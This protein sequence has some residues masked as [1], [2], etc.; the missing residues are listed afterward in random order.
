[1]ESDDGI[2]SSTEVLNRIDGIEGLTKRLSKREADEIIKKFVLEKWLC[3]VCY[4]L[5]L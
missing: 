4:G 5:L 3:Y 1:M 2:L